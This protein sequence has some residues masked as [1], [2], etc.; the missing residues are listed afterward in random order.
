MEVIDVVGI[1]FDHMHIGDQLAQVQACPQYRLVGVYDPNPEKMAAVCADLDIPSNLQY[2]NWQALLNDKKPQLAVICSSTADHPLWA[3]RLARA[4]I[5]I[6]FE[7]PF[8]INVNEAKKAI[9]SVE[10]NNVSL[11]INWPLAW[12]PVHMTAK[13]VIDQG[14]IGEITEVH[15]YD[16]NRGPQYHLHAKKEVKAPTHNEN[17]WWFKKAQGGGSLLDYLGY[18]VTLATWF[19]NGEMPLEVSTMGFIPKDGEVDLHSI[20]S[21]RYHNGLSSFQTRWGTFTDPWVNQPQP[22]CGFVIVGTKGTIC[23]KDYDTSI[24]V[25]TQ[26]QNAVHEIPVDEFNDENHIFHHLIDTIHHNKPLQGPCDY[27]LSLQGQ[28][29]VDAAYQSMEQN[30]PV[31]LKVSDK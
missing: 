6:L 3:D 26:Q 15:Y 30:R 16:G 9:K 22:F 25:Q 31:K 10:D 5:H 17:D 4:G 28:Y 21:V 20:V 2:T 11:S 24:K 29:I 8:A 18:G 14:L 12:F 7:K 27:A 19:R 23:S 1:C 13:R